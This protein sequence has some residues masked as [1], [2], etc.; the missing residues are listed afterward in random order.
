MGRDVL[1]TDSEKTWG[2]VGNLPSSPEEPLDSRVEFT[3]TRVALPRYRF[4]NYPRS[5]YRV[6]HGRDVAS[7][8]VISVR[9]FGRDLVVFRGEDNVARVLDA[10]CPHL[11]AHLGVGGTVKGGTVVCPFHG[12]A[13]DGKGV[14]VDIP[15]CDKIPVRAKIDAWQVREVNGMI[16]VWFDEDGGPPSFNLPADS[17]ESD[18]RWRYAK[19]LAWVFRS[20]VQEIV[21]NG[22]DFAHFNRLHQFLEVPT[23][24]EL[25]FDGEYFRVQFDTKRRLLGVETLSQMKAEFY[26]MGFYVT[27]VTAGKVK[28]NTF[29]TATPI[30]EELIEVKLDVFFPRAFSWWRRPFSPVIKRVVLKGIRDEFER[31]IRVWE[32]K[33]YRESPGLC[34]SDGPI[35]RVRKWC[36]QF[37]APRPVV[38][39]A[40]LGVARSGM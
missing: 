2:S 40:D 4:T 15:Y 23:P 32:R 9:Y 6:A 38:G 14:C 8:A 31:D 29:M 1:A 5:W 25:H 36:E 22:V 27:P 33:I 24:R 7:G 3:S 12:W 35:M 20:H 34:Q 28:I 37:Y 16:F 13:F 10:Y 11:G 39:G 26:G 19:T 17:A 21:E 18:L 30:D